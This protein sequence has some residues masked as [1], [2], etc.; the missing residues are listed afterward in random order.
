[1]IFKQNIPI[2]FFIR[3]FY[4]LKHLMDDFNK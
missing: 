1:M 4:K 2:S 3:M